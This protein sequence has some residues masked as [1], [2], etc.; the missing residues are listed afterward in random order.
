MRNVLWYFS[1]AIHKSN[2]ICCWC[3]FLNY[4]I[5]GEQNYLG[6]MGTARNKDN[7]NLVSNDSSETKYIQAI[8]PPRYWNKS[9]TKSKCRTDDPFLRLSQIKISVI[10]FEFKKPSKSSMNKNVKWNE[11][12][13]FIQQKKNEKNE[14]KILKN[15]TM[16]TIQIECI[17]SNPFVFIVDDL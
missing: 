1:V 10:E 17:L 7:E 14:K 3:D 9:H 5:D 11:P 8:W 4:N 12:K 15:N 16:K 2:W 6:I 13:N